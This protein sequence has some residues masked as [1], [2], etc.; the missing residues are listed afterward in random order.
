MTAVITNPNDELLI[1]R[2]QDSLIKTNNKDDV[3]LTP[4]Y[5]LWYVFDSP[6]TLNKVFASKIKYSSLSYPTIKQDSIES[7]LI[8]TDDENNTY[9]AALKLCK[10]EKPSSES[11]TL[12]KEG[13]PTKLKIFRLAD[14]DFSNNQWWANESYWVKL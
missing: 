10:I 6:V 14:A 13:F 3:I 8:L 1:K 7:E 5:P 11:I 4:V 12:P 2:Y 9:S